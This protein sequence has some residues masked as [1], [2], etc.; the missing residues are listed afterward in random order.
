MRAASPATVLDTHRRADPADPGRAG[1]A[2]PA[3]RG[4]RQRPRH[5]RARHAGAGASGAR[6]ATTTARRQR[7][8][9]RRR[10]RLVRRGLARHGRCRAAARSSFAEQARRHLGRHRP[11]VEQPTLRAAG[12]P[13]LAGTA[14]ASTRTV[15]AAGPP[16]PISARRPAAP[17][18]V[19]PASPASAACS[20]ALRPR[21][22]RC[23]PSRC[24]AR[25]RCSLSPPL[26]RDVLRRRRADGAADGHRRQRPA[27]ST[28][29]VALHDL[30]TGR[31]GH[32]ASQL[33]APL[34]LHRLTPGQPRT[35]RPCGCPAIVRTGAGRAPAR[36]D[37]QHH[38]LR[39]RQLPRDAAHLHGRAG[40]PPAPR[41]GADRRRRRRS[42]A[43][44]PIAWL[45]AGA[46]RAALLV[47]LARRR[48]CVVRRRRGA[49][50]RPGPRRR[51]GR[52]RGP[53]QGVR[54]R[55]PRGRRRQLPRRA[56]PGASACSG[57]TAP[58]R[59]PRCAC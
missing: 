22:S 13:G 39:L 20:A 48:S 40:R 30:G 25:P 21:R 50:R 52:D 17:R 42:A 11:T 2:V 41:D 34:R 14:G 3:E 15:G 45:V 33:V 38:R 56:R 1:L 35:G 8:R 10:D 36:A 49:A 55:L 46:R 26:D 37:G 24:P 28:L 31:L 32:A 57:P 47:A 16:Q 44:H 12:Y 29:F 43:A 27:T 19:S 23:C 9:D 7:R 54:R 51:P 6:A 18:R 59:P 53:G 5:R 4:R 58:A